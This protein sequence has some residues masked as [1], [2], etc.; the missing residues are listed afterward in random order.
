MA[1]GLNSHLG[2]LGSESIATGAVGAA[3]IADASITTADL[4]NNACSGGKVSAEYG[5]IEAGSPAAGG[6]S[7]LAVDGTTGAG[8]SVWVLFNGAAFAA[9]PQC[10]VSARVDG[11]GWFAVS[12]VS[13]GSALVLSQNASEKFTLLAVGSGRI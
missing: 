6:N 7:L 5:V 3:E 1:D 8:S 4:A 12:G 9:A 10:V 11:I 13:A 2:A